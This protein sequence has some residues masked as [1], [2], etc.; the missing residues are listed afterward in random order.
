MT[1]GLRICVDGMVSWHLDCIRISAGADIKG[2]GDE[3]KQGIMPCIEVFTTEK[4][5]DEA[6]V[7]MFQLS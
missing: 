4:L 1:M 3:V 2:R 5:F 7:V 6:W